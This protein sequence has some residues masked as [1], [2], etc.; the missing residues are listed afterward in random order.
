[1]LE[2]LIGRLEEKRADLATYRTAQ[3]SGVDS[4][5]TTQVD[6]RAVFLVHGR[7]EAAKQTVAR[8]LEQL[9]LDAIILSERPN[10]GRTVIEKFERNSN[11]GFAVVL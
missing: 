1:M 3:G 4:S 8:F 9:H 5:A 7:D 10:E 11:V 6:T 2:G